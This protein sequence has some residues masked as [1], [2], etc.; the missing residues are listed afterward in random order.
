LAP[1]SQVY[2]DRQI[3]TQPCGAI[4]R[5]LPRIAAFLMA[6]CRVA[7]NGM[8]IGIMGTRVIIFRLPDHSL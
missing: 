3:R 1:L 7:A 8:A 6:A 2:S 5:F 4:N